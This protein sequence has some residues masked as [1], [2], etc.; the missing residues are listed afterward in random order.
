MFIPVELLFLGLL[1]LACGIGL[2]LI[3]RPKGIEYS[4]ASDPLPTITGVNRMGIDYE[5]VHN[6]PH[7]LKSAWHI[8][9]FRD[10]QKIV[11]TENRA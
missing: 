6:W 7:H 8:P 9:K 2:Y 3:T 1:S 4:R 10:P 11:E 5:K